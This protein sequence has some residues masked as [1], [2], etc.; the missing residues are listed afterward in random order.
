MA[1][2]LRAP[3]TYSSSQRETKHRVLFAFSRLCR[4]MRQEFYHGC[5]N[6]SIRL[7]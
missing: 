6:T 3:T 4:L 1:L 5:G 2:S 7:D